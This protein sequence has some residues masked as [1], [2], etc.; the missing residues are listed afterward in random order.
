MFNLIFKPFSFIATFL[1]VVRFIHKSLISKI[2]ML[3]SVVFLTLNISNNTFANISSTTPSVTVYPCTTYPTAYASLGNIVITEGGNTDFGNGAAQTNVTFIL[4]APTNFEFQPGVGSVSF[5]AGANI[6]SASIVVTA[7]QLTVTFSNCFGGGCSAAIDVMTISGLKV[8]G[9]TANTPSSLITRSG[10]TA[11]INGS[12]IGGITYGSL[13]SSDFPTANAGTDQIVCTNTATMGASAISD[14]NITGA[15]TLVSGGG[16]ITTANSPTSAI[17]AMPLGDNIFKWTISSGSC[18]SSSVVTITSQASGLGCTSLVNQFS[19]VTAISPL[20]ASQDIL[21]PPSSVNITTFTLANPGPFNVGDKVLIIQMAGAVVNTVD[22]AVMVGGKD[23]V[24]GSISS[25]NSAGN[26]EYSIISSKSGSNVTFSQNLKNT[27]DVNGKV[28]LVNVPQ[29]ANYTLTSA[30]IGTP[31]NGTTGGVIVFEVFGT[32]TMNGGSLSMDY[33]GFRGGG[34]VSL[35]ASPTKPDPNIN[36]GVYVDGGGTARGGM[37]TYSSATC[38]P[39]TSLR[40]EGIAVNPNHLFGRGALANGGGSGAGWNSGA[41]G[42]S[43]ICAGGMGGY[44]FSSVYGSCGVNPLFTGCIPVYNAGMGLPASGQPSRMQGVGGYALTASPTEVFMG[45]GGGAGSGDNGNAT[46]G[47]NGGGIIIVTAGTIAGTTGTITSNGQKGYANNIAPYTGTSDGTGA[48]GGGGSVI[49]DVTTYSIGSLTVSVNGG[50]GGNQDQANTCHGNGGGGG[51]G[52]VRSKGITPNV[53]IS[54]VGGNIGVQRPSPNTDPN[55][56]ASLP[57]SNDNSCAGGTPYGATPGGSCG[58]SAQTSLIAVP[59]KG[60]CSPA[61]LGPDQTICGSASITLLNG[62][63]SNVNKTF[64]WY[65][66]G[67][68]I[69]GATGPTYSATSAGAYSVVAD[70]IAGGFDYCSV[71]DAI[72]I[73]NSFPTPYLG[74]NQQLCSPAYLNLSTANVGSFPVS[75]TWKWTLNGTVIPGAT[76]PDLN[77]VTD[78]GTYVLTA[79][80]PSPG[81]GPTSASITLTTVLPVVVDGCTSS[82]GGTVNLSVSGGNGGPYQWYDAQTAGTLKATGTTYSPTV[83]ATTTYWVQDNGLY[84]TTVGPPLTMGTSGS[85]GSTATINPNNV[86][87]DLSQSLNL[88]GMTLQ[89]WAN[90]CGG[91]ITYT[92]NITNASTG[93]SQTRTGTAGVCGPGAQVYTVTFATPIVIPAGTGYVINSTGSSQTIVSYSGTFPY[94]STYSGFLKMVST[95][96]GS[97]NGVAYPSLFDWKVSYNM[98]CGRVPVVATVGGSCTLPI[99]LLNFSGNSNKGIVN[100]EWITASEKNNDHFIISKS[101]DGINFVPVATVDGR[102]TKSSISN[103]SY[104]DN[105]AGSG[106]LYYKL[107]QVDIDGAATEVGFITLF[108]DKGFTVQ[109]SPNPFSSKLNVNIMSRNNDKVY[110]RVT[111]LTGKTVGIYDNLFANERIEIG[112]DLPSGLFILEVRTDYEVKTFRIV[113]LSE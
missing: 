36:C 106:V 28:Q 26:Y 95:T 74:P 8:R 99:S 38:D 111:D 77:N 48:G 10:G 68:L 69:A 22:A 29:F 71:T 45:G 89:F 79:T 100:L 109:V 81:C 54:A 110:I 61:N 34:N 53:S 27:Y 102:G 55:T 19:A 63:A 35:P 46:P 76:T 112:E 24:F 72:L 4:A 98:G 30:F 18:T 47:G 91:S 12:T 51:G 88:L 107:T 13:F 5:A 101:S 67:I 90:S 25:Y 9:I 94:P 85:I 60:C 92:I 7:T 84:Q 82:S 104:T 56:D 41:G 62:T 14:P 21:C 93:F 43:N 113:K 75:T 50:K 32:L 87:F 15:W 40:G 86:T 44:E 3:V 31:W 80:S 105:T 103:Y 49:L 58:S 66:N 20:P 52:L 17:T 2:L 108:N 33:R 70:S 23:A 1:Y 65:K 16:T 42:G 83:A 96:N 64:K 57:L 78:A 73:T 37:G 39:S 59:Q 11:V 97:S 6:T